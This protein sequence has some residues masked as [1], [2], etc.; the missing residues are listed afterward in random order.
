[1]S[2]N[3]KRQRFQSAY[4]GKA[5]WDLGRPQKPFVD[6]ADQIAGSVLDTGCG[7]GDNAL[8]FAER[9]QAVL[10]ID[11]VDTPITTARHN[12]EQRNVHAEFLQMDAMQLKDFG[13]TFDSVLDCGLFHVLSDEDR[14]L[15][16][17]GLANVTNPSG[18]VFLMCFSNEEP[19]NT[20]PRRISQSELRE[21]F[22]DGWAIESITATQFEPNPET[23][24]RDFSAGGPKAWFAVIRREE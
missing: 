17:E 23:K 2:D 21:A 9:G 19:G 6:H 14:L 5:P 13:R 22:A 18:R 12:A 24:E 10:G 3:L 7:T 20:G 16:I 1:M 15:Y 8:F 11:F 4:E